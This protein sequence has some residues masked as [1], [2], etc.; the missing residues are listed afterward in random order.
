MRRR[1]RGVDWPGWIGQ[2]KSPRRCSPTRHGRREGKERERE[3]ERESLELL[4]SV[5]NE[6]MSESCSISGG[7]WEHSMRSDR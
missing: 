2:E 3:R 4:W 6:G 5:A 7:R 1:Q